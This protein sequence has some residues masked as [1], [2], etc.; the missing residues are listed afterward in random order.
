M[1]LGDITKID[2]TELQK[3]IDLITYGFPCQDISTA[4]LRRGFW[5]NDGSKTRSGLFFDAIRIIKYCKPRIAIAEN[6]KNLTSKSMSGVFNTV[7]ASLD[8]AGYNNYWKVLNATDYGI[9]QRRERIFIVSIRKDIDDHS[10]QFPPVRPLTKC[11]EDY[12]DDDVSSEFFLSEKQISKIKTSKFYQERLRI[13]NRDETCTTLLA[14]DYKGPKCIQVA[15]LNYYNMDM[16]NRI[17][18]PKG[19][20]PTLKTVSGGG[21]EIKVVENK[22]YRKLTPKEYFRLMG[23]TD[24]DYQILVDNGISKTQLYKLAGNSI[25]VPVL[26]NL[27]H[28]IYKI[29]AYIPPLRDKGCE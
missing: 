6:V 11:M 26:E 4:G 16:P 18:S 25:V 29:G 2:E 10:F 12:L 17:Y 19:I 1:N 9:P 24:L 14:R 3:Q 8:D 7:L 20:S 15:N 21:G 27:F 13:L 23:F 28:Q 5:N 22:L